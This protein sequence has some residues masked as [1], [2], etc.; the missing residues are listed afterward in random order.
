[1]VPDKRS[2]FSIITV[3]LTENEVEGLIHNTKKISQESLFERQKIE[4]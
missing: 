3:Y 2:P 4:L 1:M